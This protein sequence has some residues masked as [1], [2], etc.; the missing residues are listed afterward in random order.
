MTLSDRFSKNLKCLR[1][2]Y[3]LSQEQ[4]SEKA[5]LDRTYISQLERS[6][7]SPTLS[8]IERIALCLQVEPH[9]LLQKPGPEPAGSFSSLYHVAE[10]KKLPVARKNGAPSIPISLIFEG[11]DEAHEMVDEMYASQLD[12]A[13]VLGMRN[14]SAFVGELLAAAIVK[15]SN[16]LFFSNPHQDG[17]PDLLLMDESGMKDWE[18]LKGRLNEKA[19]FSPFPSGGIEIKA[20]CGAVPTPKV[21]LNHG[22]ERPGIGDTRIGCLTNYDWKAHHRDTNNLL[23]IIW[24]FLN[25]RPRIVAAFYTSDLVA[26]DWGN[27]VKPKT[28]G[29]RT[30][31]VSIMTRTGITKLYQGWLCV[32][33]NGGYAEFLN[34]KN[35]DSKIPTE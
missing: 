24:D 27:V 33:K 31:S 12:I 21:A 4:L 8:T 1:E 32:L 17:Y 7:K 30:T 20:T 22:I 15:K 29:G 6:Q 18:K 14:L 9:R 23:A 3:S 13:Q 26:E 2:K 28:G 10:K 5:D 35:K 11:I 16:G 19:P 34:R 25:G